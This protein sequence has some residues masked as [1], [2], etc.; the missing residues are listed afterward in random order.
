MAL[1]ITPQASKLTYHLFTESAVPLTAV[2]NVRGGPCTLYSIE[3]N[4]EEATANL[5]WLK[6]FDHSG[7][8]LSV[9]TTDLQLLIP[10]DAVD[11]LSDEVAVVI[12][13]GLL[14]VKGLT[15]YASR[16]DGSEASA[17]PDQNLRARFVTN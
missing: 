11:G 12:P 6:I 10:L 1:T 7:A 15:F 3:V 16:E 9:G 5:C 8:G 17:A 14:L 4:N 13:G 2:E